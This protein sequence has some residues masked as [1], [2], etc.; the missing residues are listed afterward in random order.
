MREI[1]LGKSGKVALVDDA[2]F[3]R[4]KMFNWQQKKGATGKN[5]YAYR[6]SSKLE[7]AAGAGTRIAMHNFIMGE[8]P[9]GTTWD[10][11]DRDGLNNQREN[12]RPATPSQQCRNRPTAGEVGYRGVERS[13]TRWKATFRAIIAINGVAQFLGTFNSA[14]GAARAY[15]V[16]VIARDGDRAITNFPASDYAPIAKAS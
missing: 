1:P 13:A 8:P 6:T 7:R 16:A 3:D 11:R 2:D 5:F 15:D 12:L 9:A 10:H 14:E 4:V